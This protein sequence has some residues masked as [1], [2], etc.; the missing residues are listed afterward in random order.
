MPG[1][2]IT[3]TKKLRAASANTSHA[4]WCV[5]GIGVA[6][7]WTVIGCGVAMAQGDVR[8]FLQEWINLQGFFLLALGVWLLLIIRSGSLKRRISSLTTDGSIHLGMV[9][10]QALRIF[11]VSSVTLLGTA[12]LVSMG[13][14]G[15]GPV[16]NFMWITC[17]FICFTAGVVT[18]HTLEILAAVHNLQRQEV[19]VF[20]YAPARTP[21]LRSVV[22]YFTTFGLLT[23][24]GYGFA[25]FATFRAHWTG[26]R[27]YVE[28][29]RLFWPFI[30]VPIC[31]AV[32]IYPHVLIHKIIQREK[33]RTL[34]SCQ[35]DMDKILS[36]YS[37]LETEEVDRANTLAQLFD[38]I[39]A[40]PNYVVDV[41]IA[42]RT[43]LPLA[44]NLATLFIKGALGQS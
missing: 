35:Q 21:E 5:T 7:A 18:L 26:E 2:K 41:G 20:R 13:F 37:A 12:S 32:L 25:L 31:T 19:K 22:S 34:L 15:R 42:V 30:Y 10:N 3:R 33:E 23:T 17:A 36:K 9:K 1:K 40:T 29:V 39:T 44:F 8:P 38:R 14:N 16:L 6:L 43:I 24:V 27:D 4:L 28:A 11:V